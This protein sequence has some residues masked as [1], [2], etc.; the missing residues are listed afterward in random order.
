MEEPAE[1]LTGLY[2]RYHRRVLAYVLLRAEPA[3]AEDIAGETFAIAWQRIGR[4]PEA[5][6]PWLL[7]VARNLLMRHYDADRRRRML[8]ER[9]A[10]MSDERDRVGWDVADLVVEREE[11]MA[12]L[13]ALPEHY[14]EALTLVA[15]HGLT[16]AEAG[17]VVGTGAATF[18]VRLFRARRALA[19]RLRG[20]ASSTTEK[21]R[22]EDPWHAESTR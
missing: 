13:A 2:D 14:A 17:R 4:I 6:L 15:W 5:E 3:V 19:S 1:R 7:G 11:A 22:K 12:A 18:S 10:A 21:D 9:V 16:P 8:S 20:G